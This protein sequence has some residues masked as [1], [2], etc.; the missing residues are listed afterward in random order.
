MFVNFSD[1][2]SSQMNALILTREQESK[3]P[4]APPATP[5]KKVMVPR[6]EKGIM[7]RLFENMGN[8]SF[9]S[10]S[11]VHHTDE[12]QP[13]IL[14]TRQAQ[15]LRESIPPEPFSEYV[16]RFDDE[17]GG[18]D[19]V[20]APE[21]NNPVHHNADELLEMMEDEDADDVSYSRVYPKNKDAKIPSLQKKAASK[22]AIVGRRLTDFVSSTHYEK[23]DGVDF[24]SDPGLEYKEDFRKSFGRDAK[25]SL[26]TNVPQFLIPPNNAKNSHNPP[27]PPSNIPSR[28]SPPPQAPRRSTIIGRLAEDADA[29][30]TTTGLMY[31]RSP[32][33]YDHI[34]LKKISVDD[35]R[36]F[37]EQIIEYQVAH[38]Y[39]L[40]VTTM[41][42]P[43]VRE[44]VL[45]K[46]RQLTLTKFYQLT[47]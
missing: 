36:V 23:S 25:K 45:S 6:E 40:P 26:V 17:E 15:A 18:S 35:V 9:F 8:S 47:T 7:G 37:I 32:P 14:N 10:G 11:R 42:S 46:Y 28:F 43:K 21:T 38:K 30:T 12:Q 39:K 4:P 34:V 22:P 13:S 33:R 16:Q 31:V 19:E 27:P 1:V 24:S 29:I 5:P 44:E 20:P 41:L 3:V 2:I